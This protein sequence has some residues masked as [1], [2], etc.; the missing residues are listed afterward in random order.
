M[1]D[2]SSAAD[3]WQ[4]ALDAAT[5]ALGAAGRLIPPDEL[6]RRRRELVEER[7]EV[8][9]DLVLLARDTGAHHVPWLAPYPMH[10][11]SLGLPAATRA[12]VFDL[13]GV[14]T[15]SGRLHAAAWQAALDDVLLELGLPPFDLATDYSLY[16]DGRPRLEGIR[17]FLRGRG[18]GF[19]QIDAIADRKNHALGQTLRLR[20]VNAVHGARRYLEAAGHAG[21]ERAVVS[22]ST[23]TLPMLQLAELDMLLEAR[24][25]AEQIDERRLRSRPAP[26]LLLRACEL[27]AVEPVAAVTFTRT[28]DGVAAGLAAGLHVVAVDPDPGARDRLLAFGASRAIA[29]LSDLLDRRLVSCG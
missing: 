26:D 12:C 25:D 11:L 21:L 19:Q 10:V 8:A 7:R 1:H 13:D 15:D 23:R 29:R 18:I 24:V 3:D 4:L 22:G 9:A 5:G 28:P 27:L 14:L 2:L 17:L 20:G 16:F 6:R